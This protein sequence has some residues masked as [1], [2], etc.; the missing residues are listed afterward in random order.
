MRDRHLLGEST[1]AALLE[2]SLLA[3]ERDLPWSEQVRVLSIVSAVISR[4]VWPSSTDDKVPEAS[5]PQW[6]KIAN[7]ELAG[8]FW[9]NLEAQDANDGRDELVLDD[10]QLIRNSLPLVLILQHLPTMAGS[11]Q[12]RPLL[13]CI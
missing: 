6:E 5:W 12:V 13:E 11:V 8:T 3:D 7:D 10:T 1:Y 2:M 4:P 9:W